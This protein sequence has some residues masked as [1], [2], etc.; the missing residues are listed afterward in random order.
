VIQ[1]LVKASADP[2][3]LGGIG[4]V[5]GEQ[6][7]KLTGIETRALVMGHLLRGGTPTSFDR[8]LA[9]ELGTKAVDM[10]VAGDFGCMVA[11][12]G[13]ELVPVRLDL[14]ARGARTI[15]LD[16]HLIRSGRSLGTSFGD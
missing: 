3:R 1:R 15:Q 9:T 13:T 2:V 8:V 4:F 6:I 5:V 14:V 10:I 11:V 7:E 16:H 12:K